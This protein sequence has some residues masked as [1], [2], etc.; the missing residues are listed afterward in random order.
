MG[1]ID[2]SIVMSVHNGGHYLKAA[3]DS[4]RAQTLDDW[5]FIIIDDASSDGTPRLLAAAQQADSR[6]RI[7]TNVKNM[8][9]AASLNLGF[10]LARGEFIARMDADDISL[11]ERLQQQLLAFRANP[12]LVLLG[13]NIY[14]IDENAKILGIS[15]LPI[16]D[17]D[18]RC[19]C[20]LANPLAHPSVMMRRSVLERETLKYDLDFDTTQDWDLW[21]RLMQYGQ[22]GNLPDHLVM[23]RKHGS[24][25]SSRKADRQQMNSLVIQERYAAQFLREEF[26]KLRS[27]RRINQLVFG[28]LNETDRQPDDW[29]DYYKDVLLTPKLL[30]AA[31]PQK[32]SRNYKKFIVRICLRGTGRPRGYWRALVLLFALATRYPIGLWQNINIVVQR[33]LRPLGREGRPKLCFIIGGMERGGAETHLSRILPELA[34]SFDVTL[35]LFHAIGELAGEVEARGVRLYRPW[36][37]GSSGGNRVAGLFRVAVGA[38]QIFSILAWRRPDVVNFVLPASYYIGGPIAL[39]LRLHK[40]VMWRRSLNHYQKTMRP[41]LRR[42][43]WWLHGH[44]NAIIGNSQRVVDQLVL[45]EGA[46]RDRTFLIYNGVDALPAGIAQKRREIRSRLNIQEET[47]VLVIVANLIPYKGHVDLISACAQLDKSKS[48]KLLIVGADSIGIRQ[49]LEVM[50]ENL[51]VADRIDFLGERRDALELNSAADIG[52][53]C[54]YEEGFSNSIIEGMLAGLPMVVTDVGGN[55]EAVVDGVTGF[56]VPAKAPQELS[57]A[58]RRLIDDAELRRRMGREGIRRAEEEFNLSRCVC[59]CEQ[60]FDGLLLGAGREMWRKANEAGSGQVRRFN[61]L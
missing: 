12:A 47:V 11:P 8:G 44:M 34:Q 36:I 50:A 23:H 6:I 20:L 39:L 27:M 31:Y 15:D 61:G 60:L 22:V 18:V 53:L 59:E 17:W 29:W 1:K 43:E 55:A 57:R 2:V 49:N 14:H 28:N 13:T 52:I 45:E 24:A 41:I 10:G 25:V 54:S 3:I 42:I 5:E 32:C 48:W 37:T 56:V 26:S 35:I 9:L 33:L 21:S 46:P 51:G 19:Y 4:I 58:I 16:D 30:D 40:K 38:L 7:H